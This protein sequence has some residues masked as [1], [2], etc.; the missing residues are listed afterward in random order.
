MKEIKI[1]PRNKKFFNNL[2]DECNYI[3]ELKLPIKPLVPILSEFLN[4]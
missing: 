1:K 4:N 2:E 3:E